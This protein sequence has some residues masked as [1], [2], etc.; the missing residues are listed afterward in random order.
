MDYE[1]TDPELTELVKDCDNEEALGLLIE[2]H[3]GIYVDM[4]RRYASK[5]L[6]SNDIVDIIRDK[7]LIIYKAALDYDE[8]KAKFST[9]VGNKAKYL[10]LSKKTARKNGRSMLP[11]DSIDYSE[12]SSELHPD[13]S[14]DIKE[15]MLT[16]IDLINNH[17]DN[18]VKIIFKERYF[19][20]E[21]GKLQTW[22]NIGEQIGISAQGCINIHDKTL[23][24]FKRQFEKNA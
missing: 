10:C 17:R 23:K 22:K 12:E 11:F 18:R 20:G 21:R 13:E 24:E 1:S 6:P 2:R 14:C 8:N 3:S 15:S 5:S 19:G 9:H 16:V 4:V 7:D